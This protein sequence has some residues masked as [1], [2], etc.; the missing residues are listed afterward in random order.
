MHRRLL[1]HDAALAAQPDLA[2]EDEVQAALRV[3]RDFL[4]DRLQITGLAL[5]GGW[6]GGDGAMQRLSARYEVTDR[7][8]MTG[9]YVNY[10]SGDRPG[11]G[12]IGKNDRLFVE[13]KYSF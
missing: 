11:F 3:Q 6:D 9:G 8:A 10:R 7:F 13:A 12:D 1:D 2:Q 4:H 5:R